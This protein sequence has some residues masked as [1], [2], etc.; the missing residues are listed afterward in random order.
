MLIT[1]RRRWLLRL[2]GWGTYC[3]QRRAPGEYPSYVTA[4][5]KLW[6][7]WLTHGVRSNTFR[8]SNLSS[9]VIDI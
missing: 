2:F 4:S 7:H 5:H 3:G 6:W 8:D 1:I 9:H